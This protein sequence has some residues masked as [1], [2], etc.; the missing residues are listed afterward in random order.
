MGSLFGQA[1]LL[2]RDHARERRRFVTKSKLLVIVRLG[3]VYRVSEEH[4]ELYIWQGVLESSRHLGVKEV[5]RTRFTDDRKRPADRKVGRIPVPPLAE[6]AVDA[7]DLLAV[8]RA[9]IR[10]ITEIAVQGGR[11][12]ALGTDNDVVG[13]LP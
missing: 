11:A 4:Q 10:V 1:L 3:A 6:V 12:C 9:D 8:G 13:G 2:A 5:V 7:V